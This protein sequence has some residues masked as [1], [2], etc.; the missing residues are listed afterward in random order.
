M[1]RM[2]VMVRRLVLLA[3]AAAGL[4]VVTTE[5]AH[6]L[7]APNCCP[8]NKVEGV[9]SAW[10]VP[11]ATESVVPVPGGPAPQLCTFQHCEP[12]LRH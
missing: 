11:D 7:C 4:L 10:S 8:W 3:F 1:R 9:S 5:P 2:M 12:V 6:A